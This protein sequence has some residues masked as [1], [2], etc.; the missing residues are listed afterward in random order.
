MTFGE[1]AA[2]I[3]SVIHAKLR[4]TF[5]VVTDLR[6]AHP[7]YWT[8]DLTALLHMCAEGKLVPPLANHGAKISFEDVGAY[9]TKLQ[10]AKSGLWG[11]VIVDNWA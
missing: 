4:G 6:T 7:E 9:H 8:E 1:T 5:Y 2:L 11:K 3:L 10:E